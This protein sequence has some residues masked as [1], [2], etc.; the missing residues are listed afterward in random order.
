LTQER[1][2]SSLSTGTPWTNKE[3]AIL[4]EFAR[5][6]LPW[7][8][9]RDILPGRSVSSCQSRWNN[10][11]RPRDEKPNPRQKLNNDI[12]LR[13]ERFIDGPAIGGEQYIFRVPAGDPYLEKL[14]KVHGKDRIYRNVDVR[15]Q[16]PTRR[17][18]PQLVT[19]P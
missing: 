17:T 6:L 4:E 2:R 16:T 9:I 5:L 10:F 15:P 13:E 18:W 12:R 8:E 7:S 19:I 1:R 3:D 14:I 11:V